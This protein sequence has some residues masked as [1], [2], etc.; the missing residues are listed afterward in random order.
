MANETTRKLPVED[1]KD[2]ESKPAKVK[3]PI[4]EA[5]RILKRLELLEKPEQRLVLE[6]LKAMVGGEG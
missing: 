1:Y 5:R 2:A 6:K 3:D 4:L